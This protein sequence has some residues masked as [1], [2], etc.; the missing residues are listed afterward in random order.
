MCDS[1]SPSAADGSLITERKRVLW[2]PVKHKGREDAQVK[3]VLQPG[4]GP[5]KPAVTLCWF[6]NTLVSF[7]CFVTLC[8][9]D[10]GFNIFNK[11]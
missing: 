11:T 5:E 10:Q 4:D 7:K 1:T 3:V 8:I 6:I 2:T 9:P